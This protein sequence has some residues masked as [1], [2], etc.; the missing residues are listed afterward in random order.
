[1]KPKP[2]I[3]IKAE[4]GISDAELW[5]IAHRIE[6]AL[7]KSVE[8][9]HGCVWEEYLVQVVYAGDDGGYRLLNITTGH[10]GTVIGTF[11]DVDPRSFKF[12][13][14]MRTCGRE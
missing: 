1:M 3:H 10:G 7:M 5:H 4:D 14:G 9:T 2:L 6:Y 12:G 11:K 13:Y 8:E